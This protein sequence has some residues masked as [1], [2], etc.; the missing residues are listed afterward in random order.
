MS[1]QVKVTNLIQLT[2]WP[3][4]I[5]SINRHIGTHSAGDVSSIASADMLANM[6]V[7]SDSSFLPFH[8]KE[9]FVQLNKGFSEIIIVSESVKFLQW[10]LVIFSIGMRNLMKN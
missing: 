9:I 1:I 5:G 7:G 10:L 2:R 3:T 4:R 8:A 6:L